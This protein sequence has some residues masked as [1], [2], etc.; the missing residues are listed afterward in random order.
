MTGFAVPFG[1]AMATA[2][3]LWGLWTRDLFVAFA[4]S[5]PALLG[6]L[7]LGNVVHRRVPAET[8]RR[9]VRIGL[10]VVGVVLVIRGLR[11]SGVL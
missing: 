9:L 11:A 1:T 2:H 10:A 5:L 3:G 6:G 7:A 8:F 4:W